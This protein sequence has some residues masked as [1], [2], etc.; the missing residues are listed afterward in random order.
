MNYNEEQE[1]KNF[2]EYKDYHNYMVYKETYEMYKSNFKT[3]DLQNL[4][5]ILKGKL[6]WNDITPKAE[7]LYIQMKIRF[8][9]L[10]Q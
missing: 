9:N 1:I 5:K 10:L 8:D 4:Y 2:K 3:D 7:S 6:T